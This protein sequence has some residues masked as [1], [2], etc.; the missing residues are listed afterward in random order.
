M[1]GEGGVVGFSGIELSVGRPVP[2]TATVA[3][4]YCTPHYYV[5][6]FPRGG[7]VSR[8]AWHTVAIFEYSLSFFTVAVGSRLGLPQFFTFLHREKS[9]DLNKS[10]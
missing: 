10:V 1:G 3:R 8:Q 9:Y 7:T 2:A 6:T 5:Y 4:Y